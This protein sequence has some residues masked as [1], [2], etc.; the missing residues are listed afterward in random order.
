MLES[1]SKRPISGLEFVREVLI[2][3]VLQMMQSKIAH[4]RQIATLVDQTHA[5]KV[6][7]ICDTYVV[8]VRG[9]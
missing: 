4:N 6:I 2:R 7:A 3:E 5:L 1:V 8:K 9:S